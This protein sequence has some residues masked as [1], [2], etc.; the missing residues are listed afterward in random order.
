MEEL[1]AVFRQPNDLEP[2][3]R[4][5]DFG[6]RWRHLH[7]AIGGETKPPFS[8]H[9]L[10]LLEDVIVRES[11]LA[12]DRGASFG[13]TRLHHLGLRERNLR[14]SSDASGSHRAPHAGPSR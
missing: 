10:R 12:P 14:G 7:A 2:P 6:G 9:E 8:R 11:R 4:W 1:C 5:V 13:E 3:L